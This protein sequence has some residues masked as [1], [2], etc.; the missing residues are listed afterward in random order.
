MSP[1]VP[2][3]QQALGDVPARIERTPAVL[4]ELLQ[5]I[6]DHALGA[7][8]AAS[9]SVLVPADDGEHLRFLC[10]R[11][12]VAGQLATLQV[13]MRDS[14]AGYVYTTGQMAALDNLPEEKPTMFYPGVDQQLEQ[15][16]RTY[17][18]VPIFHRDRVEGVFTWVNRPGEP[19]HEPFSPDEVRLACTLAA[20]AGPILHYWQRQRQLA[21]LLTRDVLA[22]LSGDTGSVEAAEQMPA[23]TE[24]WARVLEVMDRL[25]RE[26]QELC[27]AL[28][29]VIQRQRR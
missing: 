19:P 20:V 6:L 27:A 9:V 25:P 7:V 4:V 28:V 5:D 11:G 22:A 21:R 17:L 15:T 14:I 2:T 10:A 12:V 24:P 29:E 16:T 3:L 26:D 8:N 13:P 18:A 1:P 23:A